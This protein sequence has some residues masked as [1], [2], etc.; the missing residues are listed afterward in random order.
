MDVIEATGAIVVEP[1]WTSLFN[2]ELEIA[3]AVEYWRLITTELRDKP[4]TRLMSPP[5]RWTSPAGCGRSTP[6]SSRPVPC[7]RRAHS[8]PPRSRAGW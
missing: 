8:T 6:A 2:D 3:A 5:V 4:V 7:A 1:D